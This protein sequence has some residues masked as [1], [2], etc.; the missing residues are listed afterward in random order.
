MLIAL[1]A[2]A[3]GQLPPPPTQMAEW[4]VPWD[5]RIPGAFSAEGLL[6]APAGRDGFVTARDGHFYSGDRRLRFW[7]VNVCFSA[8]FPTHEQADE[9]AARLARFGVNAVRFHHMDMRPFPGGIFADRTLEKL[10]P[11]A[12]DRLDWFVAALKKRGI[13]SNINLHVSRTLS[14]AKGWENA[15]KLGSFDKLVDIFH[16]ELIA[17]Q[18]RYARDLLTHVNAYTKNRYADEP[19]VAMVEINNEDTLFLWGGTRKL[20]ELP[21][22]YADM[23][24]A[25]WNQWL[26]KRYGTRAKLEKAWEAGAQPPGPEDLLGGQPSTAG[27]AESRWRIEQHEKAKLAVAADGQATQVRVEAVTGTA[28]H[29]QLNCTGLPS[30][31]GQYRTLSFRARAEKPGTIEVAFRQ[32]KAPWAN[33]GLSATVRVGEDETE[34]RYTFACTADDDEARV[35]FVVGQAVNTITLRD[36]HLVEGGVEGLREVEDPTHGTVAR[37]RPGRMETRPRIDDWHRFLHETDEGYFVEMRRFLRE[38]IGVK[39]PIT[40]TIALGPLGMAGQ[41]KMDFVDAHS[42]WDHPR[43]PRRQWD[44]KDWLIDNKPMVDEPARATLWGLAANRVAGKPF[45]VTE[46]NHS[47]PNDWQAECV[48]MIAAYAAL[49]DWDGVFLFAYSHN[50]DFRKDK[51]SSFFDFEGNA[52]KMPSLAAGA[53]VFVGGAMGPLAEARTVDGDYEK[54]LRSMPECYHDTWRYVREHLGLSWQQMLDARFAHSLDGRKMS[55]GT[56]NA[57]V[58]WEAKQ[59]TAGTGRFV[60]FD[61]GAAVFVGFAAGRMPIDAGPLRI[62]KLETPFA[63]IMLVAADPKQT[64]ENADRLLLIATAR[65]QNTDMQWDAQRRSVSDKWGKAPQRI[66]VVRATL[67]LAGEGELQCFALDPSGARGKAV[68][69]RDGKVQLGEAETIWYE[70]VRR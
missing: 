54:M 18:K 20:G 25:Q 39:C 33:L 55:P 28:W 21:G 37:P 60:A 51:I 34:H 52:L 68:P 29:A 9:V 30:R 35:S 16:P 53:R 62:E 6:H 43:F 38:E 1:A 4:A 66:E 14:R 45:T 57:A 46:Y 42:Y 58:R 70:L 7:G 67:T 44:G 64:I 23:L 2:A 22:P 40:G 10:S 49:Q 31:K 3:H 13:Y 12:L 24:Q 59:G 27:Q 19:A 26:T 5:Q 65:G 15:D 41:A 8:C 48:P 69:V 36:V 56:G 11:E 47:A 17:A 50:D 32:G 63:T 61:R